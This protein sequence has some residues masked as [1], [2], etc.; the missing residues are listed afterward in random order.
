MTSVIDL[1]QEAGGS[2]RA[3]LPASARGAQEGSRGGRPG[4]CRAAVPLV[5]SRGVRTGTAPVAQVATRAADAGVQVLGRQ[6]H[7][8]VAVL[9]QVPAILEPGEDPRQGL[10]LD[11]QVRGQGALRNRQAQALGA[12]GAVAQV[13]DQALRGVVQRQPFDVIEQHPLATVQGGH[14]PV[15]ELDRVG[16][17]GPEGATIDA[18]QGA[19]ADCLGVDVMARLLLDQQFLAEHL[20]LADDGD[21]RLAAFRR[22]AEERDLAFAQDVEAL[23][24]VALAVQPLAVF[25]VPGAQARGDAREPVLAEPAEQVELSQVLGDSLR[26]LQRGG[27]VDGAGLAHGRIIDK[28]RAGFKRQPLSR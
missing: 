13:G 19:G 23:R 11:R 2:F 16:E 22:L 14:H 5:R 10:G 18:V 4:R 17:Q 1:G 9:A 7:Q 12:A 20:V 21:H 24:R 28:A 8:V 15:A 3:K 6:Q 26:A 27:E 25:E